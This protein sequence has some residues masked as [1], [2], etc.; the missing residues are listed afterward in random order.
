MKHALKWLHIAAEDRQ[1]EIDR[2]LSVSIN[3]GQRNVNN[4]EIAKAIAQELYEIKQEIAI[5]EKL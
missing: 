2:V 3:N 4:T 1:K 5:L